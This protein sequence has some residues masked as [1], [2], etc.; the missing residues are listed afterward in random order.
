MAGNVTL[1]HVLSPGDASVFSP[2]PGVSVVMACHRSAA[3]I[4][5]ALESLVAQDLDR[6]LLEVVVV[7][8]GPEDGLA[9]KVAVLRERHPDLTIRYLRLSQGNASRAWNLGIRAAAR[10]FVTLLDDDDRLAPGTLGSALAAAR[11]DQVTLL[12]MWDVDHPGGTRRSNYIQDR[13]G[14]VVGRVVELPDAPIAMSYNAAKVV[15]TA[16]AREYSFDP[17]LRSGMDVVYWAQLLST[18]RP[19]IHVLDPSDARCGYE[20]TMRPGTMSRQLSLGWCRDRVGVIA[21]LDRLGREQPDLRPLIDNLVAAQAGHLARYLQEHPHDHAAVVE[22]IRS[23]CP[24]SF[25]YAEITAGK[26]SELAV[27]YAFPPANDASAIVAAR[28]ISQNGAIVDVVTCDVSSLRASDPGTAALAG[29]YVDRVE[30]ISTPP[31]FGGWGAIQQ[32]VTQGLERVDGLLAT[33]KSY[34]GL[35]SRAMW[36]AS[37][38]LAAVLK[39]QHPDWHWRAEFSDPL[40]ANAQGEPRESPLDPGSPVLADLVARMELLGLPTPGGSNVWRWAEE[41][42]FALADE[43]IFTN[44]NQRGVMLA[45][46]DDEV[47]RDRATQRAIVQPHPV[48]DPAL[49]R[50]RAALPLLDPTRLNLAY[51]GSFYANRGIGVVLEALASSPEE[52]RAQLRLHVFSTDPHLVST[53][54]H[55]LG[56]EGLVASHPYVDYLDFLALAA[57]MDVL[58]VNDVRT[59]HIHPINPYRPSKLSDY[60]GS[61]RSIWG[62]C[63]PGSPLAT[64]A[65]AY[66]SW[67]DD[68]EGAGTVL[69]QVVRDMGQPGDGSPD[70][71][72]PAAVDP[73]EQPGVHRHPGC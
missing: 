29:G 73:C 22:L 43:I 40:S 24:E 6:S 2:R 56:I 44:P 3:L 39:A 7:N 58:I 53:T 13:L 25:P 10:S 35:Y 8:N 66:R 65:T 19:R 21:H 30:T 12:P 27:L 59:S 37:H 52:V 18:A 62:I 17:G 54:A 26:A 20:R 69:A 23:Q 5:P 46:I 70:G 45:G 16:V 15:A 47:L 31:A 38:F 36:P 1:P 28:R 11:L 71:V 63:E 48:P 67:I 55:D 72:Q 57:T 51:F 50:A 68:V 9:Q 42:P 61:G 32:F 33:G 4:D 41:L 60:Q 49:Y 34:S 64:E 14:G